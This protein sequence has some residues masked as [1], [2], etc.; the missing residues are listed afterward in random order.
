MG[1]GLIDSASPLPALP[2][3]RVEIGN[4]PANT[5]PE[6]PRRLQ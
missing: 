1:M 2:E 4:N 6:Q 5:A 3:L